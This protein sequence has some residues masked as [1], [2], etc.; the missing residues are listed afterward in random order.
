MGV[1]LSFIGAPGSGKGTQGKLLEKEFGFVHI[2]VGDLFRLKMNEQNAFAQGIKDRYNKGI[3]QPDDVAG[4]LVFEKIEQHLD[5]P[6]I[7]LD[8][9]PL[10]VDQI[11]LLQDFIASHSSLS[12]DS[13]MIDFVITEEQSVTRLLKR[14][15]T[16]G[17][18]DDS[19]EIIRRRYNE[20]AT[21]MEKIIPYYKEQKRYLEVDGSPSIE[22]VY[23]NL[24][25]ILKVQSLIP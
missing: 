9:F 5:A 4:K 15:E 24:K 13:Y 8:P 14:K 23:E 1:V 16:Q 19:E 2:A 18:S 10:S 21:R 6:G 12:S 11:T 3:P 17:R 20:Y 25:Q 7:I 22:Q